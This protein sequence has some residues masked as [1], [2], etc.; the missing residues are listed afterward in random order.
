MNRIIY[1]DNVQKYAERLQSTASIYF[2]RLR[3]VI[4]I[5]KI[6]PTSIKIILK[7]R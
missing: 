4:E 6:D 3:N 7:S 1:T 2:I 5:S